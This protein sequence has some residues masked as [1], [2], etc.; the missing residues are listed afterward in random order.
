MKT[1]TYNVTSVKV[2][3]NDVIITAVEARKPIKRKVKRGHSKE[4]TKGVGP[5]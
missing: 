2:R 5:I 4:R 1:I 3:G